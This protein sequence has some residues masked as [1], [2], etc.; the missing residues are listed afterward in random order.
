MWGMGHDFGLHWLRQSTDA[1]G[2]RKWSQERIDMSFSQVH[3]LHLADLDGN[4]QPE[5]VTGKRI[6][7]HETE[8]GATD[9]P[10]V[11]SFA[12]DRSQSRWV[13]EVIYEGTPAKDAPKEAKD[14]WALDDFERGSAG[15]GLQ[16]DAQDMDGDGDID[17]VC[18]GKSGLYWFENLRIAKPK[19]SD[20]R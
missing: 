7:A 9:A 10:C 18:P 13:K 5:V 2:N 19:E 11:Y 16:M 14:R 1:D 6:Y 8:P 3:T 20:S 12:F 15:T 4:G 17:L